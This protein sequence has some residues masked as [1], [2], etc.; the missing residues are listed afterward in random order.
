MLFKKP[1]CLPYTLHLYQIRPGWNLRV[2]FSEEIRYIIDQWRP[3][4]DKTS[5]FSRCRPRCYFT[6]KGPKL[7]PFKLDSA[8]IWPYRSLSKYGLEF[9]CASCIQDGGYD[10]ISGPP[11]TSWCILHACD[12]SCWSIVHSYLLP[13]TIVCWTS[14]KVCCSL[15]VKLALLFK[16]R[17]WFGSCSTGSW[18][19]SLRDWV[20]NPSLVYRAVIIAKPWW[21]ITQ[22]IWRIYNGQA[23]TQLQINLTNWCH[24]STARQLASITTKRLTYLQWIF[25]TFS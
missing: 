14:V 25:L 11:A 5:H 8:K 20:L 3:I 19:W 2:L 15:L 17:S 4:S 21:E 22:H 7:C 12:I 6:K 10:I 24:K 16:T 18:S 9:W 23:A 1:E 13:T